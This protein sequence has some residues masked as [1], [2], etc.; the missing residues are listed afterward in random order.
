MSQQRKTAIITG[1]SGGIGQA[2]AKSFVDHGYNV[3]LTGTNEDKL[4]S[5]ESAIDS[6][7]AV[8]TVVADVADARDRGRR[9]GH[10]ARAIRSRLGDP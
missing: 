10:S 8:L 6:P 4:K 1:A 3:V 9:D 2:V 5:V 7:G